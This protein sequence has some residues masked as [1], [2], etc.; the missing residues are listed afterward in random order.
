MLH[1]DNNYNIAMSNPEPRRYA[2]LVDVY[3][4]DGKA[5]QTEIEVNKPFAINGWKIYQLSFNEQM[6]KW[7]EYSVFELVADPWQS[8]VYAGIFL[9]LAGAIGMFLTASTNK[10]K[11]TQQ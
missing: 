7:S 10:R 1:L 2:S 9:L 8:V 6:G 11:E 4:K 3:T 5:E